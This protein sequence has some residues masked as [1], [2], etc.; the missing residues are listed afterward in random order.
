MEAI[1]RSILRKPRDSSYTHAFGTPDARRA[2]ASHH[3]VPGLPLNPKHV[4]VTNGCSGALQLAL[5]SLLDP[6]TILLVPQPGFPLYEEIAE[7]QR[8]IVVKY[9][10]DPNRNWECD[11]DH[12]EEIMR[13][14]K[15]NVRA[16]VV[17]N[18]S[19]HGAVF[20]V[21]HLSRIL[22]FALNH[23]LP[24]VS[25]EVYGN[26]TFGSHKFHPLSN[27]A[28]RHGRKVPVITTS[29]LS[30]Q[31]L[32]PGWRIGWLVFH[33]NIWGSLKNVQAAAEKLARLQHGVS[34]L[35]QSAISTLLSPSTSGLASWRENLRKMLEDQAR[36]LSSKLGACRGLKVLCPP[37]GSMYTILGLDLDRFD[38]IRN[39]VDFCHKLVR[40]EN[41]FVLPG[42]SFEVP[43][44]IRVAFSADKIT[45]AT[46]IQRISSFCDRHDNQPTIARACGKILSTIDEN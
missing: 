23:R 1:V 14:K 38:G 39:D 13:T 5:A 36:F 37:Q 43:G 46:A 40:E 12:L 16:M 26:L 27:I 18:P 11:M 32:V 17:N 2:I 10:L 7:S 42:S 4:I 34:H 35:Q 44:T 9:C 24:I 15:H 29:S 8:A 21:E 30:K 45:L 28:A 3:S 19:S 6:G 22:D 31:F 25:D 20:T 41:V 33:D